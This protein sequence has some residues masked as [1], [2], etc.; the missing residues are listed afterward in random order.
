MDYKLTITDL[1]I[2]NNTITLGVFE[3]VND[4]DKLIKYIQNNIGNDYKRT[5]KI[6]ETSTTI[7]TNKDGTQDTNPKTTST[8]AISLGRG[9]NRP[10][11]KEDINE[12]LEGCT[13]YEPTKETI[14]L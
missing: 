5:P 8:L 6:V 11:L 1:N 14:I 7:H 9:Y 10:K 13:H 12:L 4:L 2:Y 3:D